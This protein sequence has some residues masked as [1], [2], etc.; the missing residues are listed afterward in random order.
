MDVLGA[1]PSR[2]HHDIYKKTLVVDV[3]I[4]RNHIRTIKIE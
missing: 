3:K 2:S 1:I 4:V